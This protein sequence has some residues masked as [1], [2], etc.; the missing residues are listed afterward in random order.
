[1][2]YEPLR[3][4]EKG[5]C[6]SP[7]RTAEELE[8]AARFRRVLGYGGAVPPH[9]FIVER[10]RQAQNLREAFSL[11]PPKRCRGNLPLGLLETALERRQP[12]KKHHFAAWRREKD[13]RKAMP[14]PGR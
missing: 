8:M 11:R 14:A 9:R 13:W 2:R 5:R 1:M 3:A 10:F 4:L 12:V 6:V 7:R